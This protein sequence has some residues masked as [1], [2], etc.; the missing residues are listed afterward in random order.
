MNCS[1]SSV[2]NVSEM[3]VS[4]SSPSV[5]FSLVH[6]YDIFNFLGDIDQ[7]PYIS[8]DADCA[9]FKLDGREDYVIL[10]CDG[11]FDGIEPSKVVHIVQEHLLENAG[12][13]SSVAET[14]VAA[15]KEGGSNDNITVVVFFLQ[16]P[17]VIL[18]DSQSQVG[19]ENAGLDSKCPQAKGN[20]ET[21]NL[22]K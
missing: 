14:L 11:F 4:I 17:Q 10:A 9:T 13:G 12:D 19:S 5:V 18:K 15:A 8:G 7:K 2:P 20:S 6:C 22:L 21:V 3:Q 1:C 16:D